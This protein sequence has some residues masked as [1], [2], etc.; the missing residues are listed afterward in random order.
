MAE[1]LSQPCAVR[2]TLLSREVTFCP[3][4][5]TFC[6]R[7]CNYCRTR[8]FL[9]PF[10]NLFTLGRKEREG[11]ALTFFR[12]PEQIRR[13]KKTLLKASTKSQLGHPPPLR[14]PRPPPSQNQHH[15]VHGIS[16]ASTRPPLPPLPVASRAPTQAAV[17]EASKFSLKQQEKN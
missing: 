2:L 12:S 16:P 6:D 9:S 13:L 10:H 1:S 4:C 17:K 14:P 3:C 8:A 15:I 5:S 11:C 7:P